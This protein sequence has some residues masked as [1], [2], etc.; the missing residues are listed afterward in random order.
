MCTNIAEAWRKRR[1]KNAF[2][3]K[4]N[5]SEAEAAETHSWLE[6][7]ANCGYLDPATGDELSAEYEAILGKLVSM[8]TKPD[9]WILSAK[10]VD[11]QEQSPEGR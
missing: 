11:T 5:D 2:K 9:P 3:S 7:S 8:I 1:Y 4:L 6:F 10:S